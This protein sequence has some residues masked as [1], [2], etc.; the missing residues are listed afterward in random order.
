MRGQDVILC[1]PSSSLVLGSLCIFC[2]GE[3]NFLSDP[4]SP[5][6]SGSRIVVCL[7]PR[8]TDFFFLIPCP[9]HSE[10]F[11]WTRWA[12]GDRFCCPSPKCSRFL[13]L[14][15]ESSRPAFVMSFY[16]SVCCSLL[17]SPGRLLLC[18]IFFFFLSILEVKEKSLKVA[19]NY[20]S[21]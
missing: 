1:Y 17:A 14:K 9:S 20:P 11:A 15:E 4:A 16:S 13:L 6:K 5:R 3:W 2:S 8:D 21:V 10:I 19:M 12:V 7:S 18:P